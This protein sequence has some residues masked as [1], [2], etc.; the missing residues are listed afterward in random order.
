M[1]HKQRAITL[2]VVP[3]LNSAFLDAKHNE[4]AIDGDGILRDALCI[5]PEQVTPSTDACC[6]DE[7]G[8]TPYIPG[9]G[10]KSYMLVR[11]KAD[12]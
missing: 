5:C 2:F 12:I 8:A 10:L 11:D 1:V 4:I 3:L 6:V 7:D 9:V